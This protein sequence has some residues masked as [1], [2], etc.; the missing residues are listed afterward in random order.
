VRQVGHLQ[1]LKYFVADLPLGIEEN[2]ENTNKE[3][4]NPRYLK[5]ERRSKP[6]IQ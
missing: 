3:N 6:F 5:L 2:H 4:Q 1:R